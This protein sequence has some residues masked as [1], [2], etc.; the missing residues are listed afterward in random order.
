MTTKNQPIPRTFRLVRLKD[1]SGVSGEGIVAE[2]IV[3]HDG[4]VAMSW[5]GIHHTLVVAPNIDEITAIH[6]HHGLTKV[7]WTN[8]PEENLGIPEEFQ[9]KR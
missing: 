2:G 4:Q 8:S 1:V 5:F 6:G 3:F 7:V 9:D